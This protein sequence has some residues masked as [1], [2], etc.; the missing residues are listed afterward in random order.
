MRCKGLGVRCEGLGVRCEMQGL[1]MLMLLPLSWP[2]PVVFSGGLTWRGD[3]LYLAASVTCSST[4]SS[5]SSSL[6]PRI[7]IF[8]RT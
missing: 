7:L 6:P 4:S 5:S 3:G 8:D 2:Y 1:M